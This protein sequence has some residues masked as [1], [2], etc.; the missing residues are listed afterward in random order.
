MRAAE[1]Q[2]TVH[3]LFVISGLARAGTE[4]R[5]LELARRLPADVATHFCIIGRPLTLLPELERAA[6]SVRVIPVSRI[7]VEWATM[8]RIL[9]YIAD[10]RPGV[11]NAF[12]LKGLIIAS[13]ARLL[14][15]PRPRLVFHIVGLQ[16][17]VSRAQLSALWQL[18]RRA[19]AVICESPHTR[20]EVIGPRPVRGP[21]V[22][23]PNGV[24]TDHFAPDAQRRADARASL[25]YDDAHCVLGTVANYQPT[26]NYALL[27]TG[28]AQLSRR[29]PQVRLLC[30]GDG[31]QFQE[32]RGLVERLG[33]G[34]L[35]TMTG[36]VADVRPYLAAMDVFALCS[37]KEAFS[38]A[39]LQAMASG[40]PTLCS[41]TG[42]FQSV[43]ADGRAGLLFDPE[44]EHDFVTTVARVVED[45][46]LRERLARGA[47]RAIEE[48]FT[49]ATMV[50]G[51]AQ[52]FREQG[53]PP[54]AARADAAPR[55]P[56][57]A[58]P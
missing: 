29:L 54:A 14:A 20:E 2:A 18:L 15:R 50:D 1:A 52:F 7:W 40:L 12:D 47:R 51:Y 17:G 44:D 48:R 35:V 27:I 19:D 46:T 39:V 55:Q 26:K 13:L 53:A 45:P 30:V 34:P 42:E 28:F 21:V 31:P 58:T 22:V 33:V 23:I 43:M 9:R 10:V 16:F 5:M 6:A 49:L 25:G 8:R 3:V 36:S 24:D 38:N 37:F 57:R 41:R 32:M 56:A 11:V 4:L